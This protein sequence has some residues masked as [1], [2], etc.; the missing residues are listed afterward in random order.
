MVI[1]TDLASRRNRRENFIV[2]RTN[3][4]IGILLGAKTG[5]IQTTDFDR[6]SDH[7]DLRREAEERRLLYVA[8]TRARDFVIIPA[9]FVTPREITKEGDPWPGSLLQ[10]L[11]S[12][13]PHP[14]ELEGAAHLNGMHIF[15]T[16]TLNLQPGEA[17]TFRVTLDPDAPQGPE[18]KIHSARLEQW[19]KDQADS[20]A[21]FARGRDLKTATEEKEVFPGTE[22]TKGAIFGQLVHVIL[23]RMDWRNPE[24][25]DE[26]VS[27]EARTIGADPAL[28]K[29][30]AEMIRR[31]LASDLIARIVSADR[32]YKE[33]P[34]AFK[35]NGTI[36]EGVIDVIFEEDDRIGI[37]DFKTDKVAKGDTE[38]RAEIY[39]PQVETYRR[40][41]TAACGKAPEE[42]ILYFL[43][44]M[45]TVVVS[46]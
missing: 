28:A 38:R 6:L 17:P 4:E 16:S 26:I 44:P 13:I 45:E 24:I 18:S 29:R 19:N 8:M 27:A 23:E 15:D 36:V 22:P 46:P 7:E 12:K 20:A 30:A 10:Y 39:R 21:R 11:A 9:Y 40:A 43:H 14:S 31:T 32:Y 35:E 1:L 33:V 41:V 5:G 2:N 42:V 37:V 3:K 25:L 34:F